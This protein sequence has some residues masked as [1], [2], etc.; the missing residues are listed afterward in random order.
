MAPNNDLAA[1]FKPEILTHITKSASILPPSA[2]LS[3][4]E[5]FNTADPIT[6]ETVQ[7]PGESAAERQARVDAV[8]ATAT[9]L[10][11]LVKKKKKPAAAISAKAGS[12]GTSANGKRKLDDESDASEGKK[13]KFAVQD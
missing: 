1:I 10:S 9:D 11:G 7:K 8:S 4:L 2:T 5:G 13:V 3:A 12:N 6:G